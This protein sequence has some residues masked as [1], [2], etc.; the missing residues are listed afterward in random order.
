MN[1]RKLSTATFIIAATLLAFSSQ[2]QTITTPRVASPAAK[3]SQTV[4]ISKVTVKY[5]RPSV[6]GREIWGKLVPYGFVNLGFGTA[7][8]SPWR[9][10]ANENTTITFSDDAMVEG[11]ALAAGTY[12]FHIAVGEN[13][14]ATVIFSNNSSSWGSYFYNPEEDALR[15]DITTQEVGMTETLTYDFVNTGKNETTLVLDWEKKRF[16][17]SIAFATDE[18][19]IANA[20]NELRGTTGFGWQGPLSAANYCLQNNM[21]HEQAIAWADQSIQ[22]NKNFQ[23]L[24][25]KASLIKQMDPNKDVTAMFDEAAEMANE[26]QLNFLGYQ[27]MTQHNDTDKAIAYFQTNVKKHPESANAHDS[28]GEAYK[29]AGMDKQAIKTLKKALTLNPAPNVKA[30]SIKLLKELGVEDY[31]GVE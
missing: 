30:N 10:G 9:A 20:Q 7:E 24:F 26:G 6:K 11:K 27:M 13:N 28:L 4:G 18:I 2:A 17:V 16:P 21:N 14:D 22:G 5:S 25:V 29:T 3:I 8:T 12:G 23:N 15:A 1:L 19:V 31:A